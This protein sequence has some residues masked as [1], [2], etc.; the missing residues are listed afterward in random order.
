MFE[1]VPYQDADISDELKTA[2]ARAMHIIKPDGEIIRAGEAAM[3]ILEHTGYRWVSGPFSTW[4]LSAVSE[5]GYRI[6]A[7]NRRFFSKFM[8]KN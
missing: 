3:F 7:N 6:V 2:C 4:P 5:M 8:F 1:T